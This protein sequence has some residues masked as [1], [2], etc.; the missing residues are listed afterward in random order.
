[1]V[2]AAREMFKEA[3]SFSTLC[4]NLMHFN[5]MRLCP[6]F[7]VYWSNQHFHESY[8]TL[9]IVTVF[10][11]SDVK[12]ENDIIC[13]EVGG[14][15]FSHKKFATN[16]LGKFFCRMYGLGNVLKSATLL[17]ATPERHSRNWERRR[18]ATPFFKRSDVGVALLFK[19]GS[20]ATL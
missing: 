18:S 14:L 8:C 1:M 9:L 19:G 4:Q 20:G 3:L 17:S 5:S 15:F 12:T 6:N 16:S 7:Y 11:E 2:S 13:S 10:F